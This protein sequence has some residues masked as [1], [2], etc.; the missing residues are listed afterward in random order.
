MNNRIIFSVLMFLLGSAITAALFLVLSPISKPDAVPMRTSVS[1][2]VYGD[3]SGASDSANSESQLINLAFEVTSCLQK[4]DYAALSFYAHPE[5]GV[6][7]SPFS[8]VSLTSD[9]C[10]TANEISRFRKD[11]TK[12]I[13]G[14]YSN[15]KPIELTPVDYFEEFVYDAGYVLPDAIGVDYI[16]RSGNALENVTETFPDAHY[17]DLYINGTNDTDWKTLRLVFEERDGK[18]YLT[19]II[20]SAYTV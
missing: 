15:G 12:Y 16:V 9:K 8:T 1:L 4:R 7:F 19:A 2:Q 18:Q 11:D 14:V 3:E 5:F 17:V 6:V 13:W 10:F 20:H